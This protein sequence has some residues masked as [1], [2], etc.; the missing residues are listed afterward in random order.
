MQHVNTACIVVNDSPRCQKGNKSSPYNVAYQ[1][2]EM[3]TVTIYAGLPSDTTN[4]MVTP[5]C[6]LDALVPAS[7]G[8]V[9]FGADGC[10]Y[11]SSSTQINGQCCRNPPTTPIQVVNPYYKG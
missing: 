7:Y 1:G 9:Y 6:Q 8:D 2:T 5:G 3:S 10:L 4:K 11:D